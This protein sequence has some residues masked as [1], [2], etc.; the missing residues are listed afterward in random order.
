MLIMSVNYRKRKKKIIFFGDSITEAGAL[1]GGYIQRIAAYLQD[2][3]IAH[4]YDLMGMG[5]SGNKVTDLQDR[6]SKD[7]LEKGANMVVIFIGVND[8]WHTYMDD[9]GVNM[10]MF[11]NAYI[12][13]VEKLNL[14]SIKTILCTPAVIGEKITGTNAADPAL[15]KVCDVIR[16][17]SANYNLPLVDLRNTF[18][19]YLLENNPEN[20]GMGILTRD[21]VHLNE[22]GNQLAANE[23]WTVI[24]AVISSGEKW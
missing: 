10:D 9:A 12:T 24:K 6:L 1:F 21:G 14:A 17:I 11:A 23:I 19:H 20:T 3:D 2:E 22:K 7:I 4:K 5:K 13:I 16:N 18:T 8:V 15:D